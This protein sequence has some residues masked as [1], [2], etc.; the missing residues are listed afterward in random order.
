[1]ITTTQR[2]TR[3]RGRLRRGLVAVAAAASLPVTGPVASAALDPPQL[4]AATDEYLF[5]TG[6]DDFAAAHERAPHADQL[7]WSS[8]GCSVAPDEPLGFDFT[9]SCWR[10]D[11]GYRN[12]QLQQRFSEDNRARIDENF[13]ADMTGTCGV[14]PLCHGTAQV[15]YWAVREFGDVATSTSDAVERARIR[16]VHAD[17]RIVGFR[18]VDESGDPVTF[19]AR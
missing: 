8:D 9:A 19:T 16:P 5:H 10:H 17:G 18:A 4:R 12:Y 7:D 3:T 2:S 6:L 14:N 11:F 15:Y 1:M 13:R